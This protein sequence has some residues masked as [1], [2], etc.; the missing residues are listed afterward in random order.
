MNN[1]IIAY[2]FL[3]IALL[4]SGGVLFYK[5]LSVQDMLNFECVSQFTF[6]LGEKESPPRESA[7]LRY[8]IK[9]DGTGLYSVDGIFDNGTEQY[10]VARTVHFTYKPYG[11]QTY[12][13][14]VTAVEI[15]PRETVPQALYWH[16]LS[17]KVGSTRV[18]K[19]S[20]LGRD[21]FILGTATTPML[22]CT[23]VK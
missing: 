17:D 20:K 9:S 22:V 4:I 7:I 18:S 11:N 3:A 14:T 23:R 19:I 1:K 5:K 16:Y 10:R 12:H 13:F 21:A 8:H 2:F 6:L 15:T